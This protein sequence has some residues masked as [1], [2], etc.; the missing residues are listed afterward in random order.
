MLLAIPFY[1]FIDTYKISLELY[2]L[3]LVGGLIDGLSTVSVDS[4]YS[5]LKV[6]MRE[7]D[8]KHKKAAFKDNEI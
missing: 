2:S 4:L 5:T 6:V 8:T 3:C 7:I 1:N